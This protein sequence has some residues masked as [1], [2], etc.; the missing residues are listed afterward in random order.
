MASNTKILKFR[1]ALRKKKAGRKAKS[2]R[3]LHG[4]TPTF[5]IHTPEADKNA[6]NQAKTTQDAS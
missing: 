5:D 1:R 3:A 6:P 2:Q 4:S